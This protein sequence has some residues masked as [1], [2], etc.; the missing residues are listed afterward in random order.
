M[1]WIGGDTLNQFVEKQLFDPQAL[2]GLARQFLELVSDLR[3]HRIA[4]GDL[5]HANILLAAGELRLIDY[6]GMFV[7]GLEGMGSHELGN[8][9]YQHPRRTE[10]DFGPNA[11]NF[12][13]WSIYLSLVALSM[14][15]G[16]WQQ[17]GAGDEYLLFKRADYE[18]PAMSG[19]LRALRQTG[20]TGA[21][22]LVSLLESLLQISTSQ[23]PALDDLHPFVTQVG[24]LPTLNTPGW[25]TGYMCD[26]TG[27]PTAS[28]AIPL[29]SG[30]VVPDWLQT[31]LEQPP[32][33]ALTGNIWIERA[34]TAA[35]LIASITLIILG[36]RGIFTPVG[37]AALPTAVL[38]FAAIVLG[39]RYRALPEARAKKTACDHW[40]ELDKIT[41]DLETDLRRLSERRKRQDTEETTELS[42]RLRD[43]QSSFQRNA[44][45]H[46][47]LSA[48]SVYGIGP[49]LTARLHA[50]GVQSAADVQYW[51]V[52]SVRGIG[53]VKASSLMA[54]R[55]ACESSVQGRIPKSLPVD[56]VMPIKQKYQER[57]AAIDQERSK[58]EAELTQQMPLLARAKADLAPYARVT[59]WLYVR[60]IALK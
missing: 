45:S 11:D 31:H 29:P 38:V 21:L 5:Q 34:V 56:Q 33:V 36:L 13:T 19:T 49:E 24:S 16:L 14:M 40:K 1:E 12:S 47:S 2:R 44:L 41:K 37:A 46:M 23:V 60:R 35:S 53:D 42:N 54:W 22:A 59:F 55:R 43:Y 27:L 32:L 48:G 8:R 26:T 4:H 57:A 39:L 10:H 15:P 18:S 25:L 28:A 20:N 51:R 6:D 52:K 7:P 30:V 3:Q 58:K 9:N 50:A 17:A